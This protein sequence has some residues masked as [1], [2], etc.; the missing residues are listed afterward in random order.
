MP[1]ALANPAA[2]G[3]TATHPLANGHGDAAAGVPPPSAN[4]NG[5][6]S[7]VYIS[8]PPP[9]RVTPKLWSD[10]FEA[11][12]Q[13]LSEKYKEDGKDLPLLVQT[14]IGEINETLEE[15]HD[16]EVEVGRL[17]TMHL[18]QAKRR[19]RGRDRTDGQPVEDLMVAHE[20]FTDLEG[21]KTSV[22][23]EYKRVIQKSSEVYD[24]IDDYIAR[25]D[26][27]IGR[28][29]DR[30]VEE[31]ALAKQKPKQQPKQQQQQQQQQ[32]LKRK[33]KTAADR[34][35]GFTT[36]RKKRKR[37]GKASLKAKAG[38]SAVCAPKEQL[39]LIDEF[40]DDASLRFEPV[41]C[42]CKEVAYG[43]M[44]ECSDEGC[45]LEWFHYECMGIKPGEAPT[46]KWVCP[47]CLKRRQ[48]R[49]EELKR[50]RGF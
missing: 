27:E 5:D 33:G 10:A 31:K 24:R 34:L 47:E 6:K 4:G 2:N 46:G 26:E 44:I 36:G 29:Q 32:P 41:Y 3:P 50:R 38:Q 11:E 8:A 35:H 12:M 25:L 17:R 14:V 21:G 9:P 16:T 7:V 28:C 13:E 40:D 49:K 43:E 19:V 1:E 37:K 23:K 30:Y 48:K 42:L 39:N 22:V 20:R 45:V 18:F 15:T